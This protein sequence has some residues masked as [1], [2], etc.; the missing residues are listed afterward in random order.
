[1]PWH[2]ENQ[3]KPG[4]RPPGDD[5]TVT[6]SDRPSVRAPAQERGFHFP[7]VRLDESSRQA[8]PIWL[9]VAFGASIG[10]GLAFWSFA[11]GKYGWSELAGIMVLLAA[12]AVAEA[13]PVPIEGVA[14]GAT[15]LATIFLVAIAAI[16]GWPAAAVAGL[17]AMALVEVARRRPVSRIA[18]NCGVYVIAGIAAGTAAATID[19]GTLLHLVV[20]AIAAAVCFYLVDI[21]LLAAVVSRSRQLRFLSS[22][23]NYVHLTLM[24]FAIM[25]SLTV[26]L[27]VLWDRSPYVAVVLAGPLLA[28]AIYQRWIHGALERLREFDR[29]KDEFIAIVSHE[30]RTP[31]TSVYGAAVT[32]RNR[33]L[34]DTRRNLLLDIV[35]TESARLGRLLDDV[36]WV[37][38]LDSGRAEPLITRVEPRELVSDVVDATRTHLPPG[39]SLDFSCDSASLPVAADPDRLRQVLVNLI[40][41]AVKYSGQG[42]IEVRVQPQYETTRFSVRDE[43]R[44]IPIGEAERIFEKFYRLDPDMTEGVGGTGLGLYICRELIEGMQGQIWVNSELGKGSTFIF[45][46]PLFARR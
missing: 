38:R 36:L 43:G 39:L 34:D 44:G 7:R 46:L 11:S 45:E 16:Y 10:L 35:S 37:S 6:L 19:H 13:F 28:T 23:R 8:S 40:E 12:A 3:P 25:A 41:N 32:L 18:F 2:T 31:L 42:R 4:V 1:M 24:P 14:V 21:T 9:P 26:V 22:L 30:L 27:V 33:E 15:S 17:L 5:R 29:L 20:G